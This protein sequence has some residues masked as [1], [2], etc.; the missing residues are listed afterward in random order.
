VGIPVYLLIPVLV[1]TQA[2]QAIQVL[3][4]RQVI[5]VYL[6]T[7]VCQAILVQVAILVFQVL[8]VLQVHLLPGHKD[9]KVRMVQLVR[10]AQLDLKGL[11][12]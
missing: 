8:V 12:T 7:L 10:K 1:A 5:V 2:Y 11:Q 3:A 6:D 9:L 4:G